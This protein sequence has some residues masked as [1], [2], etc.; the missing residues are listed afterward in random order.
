MM[1]TFFIIINLIGV[2]L[3]QTAWGGTQTE[4]DYRYEMEQFVAAIAARA[5]ATNPQFG[6]FAQNASELG[7]DPDYVAVLTGIGQEDIYYGYKRD[8]VPTPSSVTRELETNLD[9]FKASGKLVLTID[10]PFKK[11]IPPNLIPRPSRR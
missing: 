9:R 1:V 6:I 2:L 8:G 5:R 3:V 7:T 4:I 10:Y 11:R